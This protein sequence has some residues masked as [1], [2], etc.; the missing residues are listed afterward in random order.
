M[1]NAIQIKENPKIF[2]ILICFFLFVLLL[3]W[4]IP[5]IG[6]GKILKK[7]N[8]FFCWNSFTHWGVDK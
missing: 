3:L 7:I 8:K 5:L 4:S 6:W 2:Q 1:C